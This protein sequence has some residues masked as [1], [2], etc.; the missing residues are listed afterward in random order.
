M[1][2][3]EREVAADPRSFLGVGAGLRLEHERGIF[4][5]SHHID[6]FELIS[7]NFMDYGGKPRRAIANLKGK[8]PL[9]CHGLGL[10]LGSCEDVPPDY[11]EALRELLDF[12]E[13][14]WF[15]DHLCI[16]S[17]LKHHYHDLLPILKTEDSLEKTIHKIRW[18]QRFFDRP[19]AIENITYYGESRH[20]TMEESEF[21]TRLLAET[22]CYLLLDI[23][24]VY[25]NEKNLGHKAKAFLT[26]LPSD[27]VIQIHLAGHEQR[28]DFVI[29]THGSAVCEE[30]WE[31]YEWYLKEAGRPINTLIEWDN[32]LPPFE[33][34]DAQVVRAKGVLEKLF[35]GVS[36]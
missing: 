14:R 9:V 18:I 17:S 11:C 24:N 7:E 23:N 19:F 26:R 21:I 29:D 13:A 6:W 12:T 32:N 20:H 2:N 31:L 1:E 16:S 35:P 36:S 4:E 34:L 15:S 25:V 33:T 30:V 5:T 10:S 28:Q 22:S 3:A 8:Y 27:R